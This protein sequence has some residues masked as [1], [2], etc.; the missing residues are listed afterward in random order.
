MEK[1]YCHKKYV[2]EF[3]YSIGFFEY[4]KPNNTL[5]GNIENLYVYGIPYSFPNY[6]K[7][8]FIK[9]NRNEIPSEY[10]RYL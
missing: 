3:W 4:D 9:E 8:F 1:Y 10:L 7:K 6:R 5:I 2:R